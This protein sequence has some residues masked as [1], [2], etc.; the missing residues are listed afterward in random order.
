MNIF[1]KKTEKIQEE[2]SKSPVLESSGK[3]SQIYQIILKPHLTEKSSLMGGENKYTFKVA[4]NSNK[5]QI[6]EAIQQIYKVNVEKVAI[7]IMPSK[8]RRVGQREGT[9]SGFKKAIVTLA[10]GNKIEV[11]S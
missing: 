3:N 5:L 10:E 8:S 11:T 1:N 4:G 2:I 6:K 9:K 7:L